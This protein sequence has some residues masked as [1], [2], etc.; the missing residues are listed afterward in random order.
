MAGGVRTFIWNTARKAVSVPACISQWIEGNLHIQ[1][2]IFAP[3]EGYLFH[4]DGLLQRYEYSASFGLSSADNVSFTAYQE[5]RHG[6]WHRTFQHYYEGKMNQDEE[7][8]TYYE[9]G[10][11]V[12]YYTGEDGQLY[13]TMMLDKQ[14]GKVYYSNRSVGEQRPVT[15]AS[16]G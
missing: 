1:E 7:H 10:L 11:P 13:N 16:V 14:T 9:N 4:G 15:Y 6:E 3:T 5:M 8:Y 12:P 2:Y